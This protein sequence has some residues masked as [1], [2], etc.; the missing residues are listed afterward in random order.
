MGLFNWFQWRQPAAQKEPQTLP[1]KSSVHDEGDPAPAHAVVRFDE[2]GISCTRPPKFREQVRWCDLGAII[3]QSAA[4]QPVRCWILM[5]RNGQGGCII[6]LNAEGCDRLLETFRKL[7]GFNNNAVDFASACV[8]LPTVLC[9]E[10]EGGAFG[11]EPGRTG[12]G[13]VARD[14][15]GVAGAAEGCE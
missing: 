5:A 8:D 13:R 15:G 12:G 1:E 4:V 11:D 10:R 2:D 7:P 14:H 6:P 9:W 3:I